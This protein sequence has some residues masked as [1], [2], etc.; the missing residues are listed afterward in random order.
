MEG[1]PGIRGRWRVVCSHIAPAQEWQLERP[2]KGVYGDTDKYSGKNKE[3]NNKN[4][5]SEDPDNWKQCFPT[6][7]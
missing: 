1:S 2:S 6:V 5:V 4:L 3:T 7:K